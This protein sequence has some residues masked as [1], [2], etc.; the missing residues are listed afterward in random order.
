MAGI[1]MDLDGLVFEDGGE[2]DGC[3]GADA[4]GV[5]VDPADRELEAGLDRAGDGLLLRPAELLAA[6]A[7]LHLRCS[8]GVHA[9]VE[10]AGCRKSWG[11]YGGKGLKCGGDGLVKGGDNGLYRQSVF[12]FFTTNFQLG[13]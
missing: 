4:L 7:L 8:T 13:R 12:L 9:V 5:A 10:V 6:G 3:A 2:V 11:F 1:D